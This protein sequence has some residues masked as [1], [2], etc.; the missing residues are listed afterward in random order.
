MRAFIECLSLLNEC[1]GEMDKFL[2]TLYEENTLHQ[3]L[4]RGRKDRL[5]ADSLVICHMERGHQSTAICVFPA[6]I[7]T[8]LAAAKDRHSEPD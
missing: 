1:L 4:N 5:R 3:G 6:G 8:S 7:E 2:S